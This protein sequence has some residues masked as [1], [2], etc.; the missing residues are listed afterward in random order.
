MLLHNA[1]YVHSIGAVK[2]LQVESSMCITGGVD[3]QIKIWD[4]DLAEASVPAPTVS[5]TSQDDTSDRSVNSVLFGSE[6]DS[7][8]GSGLINDIGEDEGM[9]RER[10]TNG[11]VREEG[12]V[13]TLDGHTRAVTCL[14]FEGDC[15]VCPSALRLFVVDRT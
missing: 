1:D 2:T 14:Y 11:A 15:L 10:P 8:G 13:R 7:S 6:R 9:M 5:P 12:L 4:L 3:G